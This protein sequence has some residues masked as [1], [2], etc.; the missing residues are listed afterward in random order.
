LELLGKIG[1]GAF[2]LV[3][4]VV[5]LRLLGLA[6][7]TRKLPELL[8]GG[9]MLCLAGLGYPLSAVAREA[10]SL[11]EGVR[12]GLGTLA[13]LLAVLGLVANTAFTWVLFRR[14]ALWASALVLCVGLGSAGLFA[15]QTLAGNWTRG[16]LF[17]G[18]LPFGITLSFGWAC[19]ECGRYHLLLRRRL[20]IGLADPIVTDRFG[21][22]A[23]A[24]CLAVVTNLV[25]QV[26]WWLGVEMLTDELGS[27]LLL[28]LGAGSTV[29]MWL[30]FL[31][32]R[33]YLERVRLR[34]V[35]LA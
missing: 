13:G 21:L 9:S 27:F 2:T 15:A 18:W 26:Y 30:A 12:A 10:A 28:V 25:G 7:R 34:S 6:A 32:P 17:W 23:A 16:A 20:R 24:T 4:F 33:A 11:P 22:Y 1:G 29:L 5:G 8:I 3:C 35:A 14:G 31:P 19:L